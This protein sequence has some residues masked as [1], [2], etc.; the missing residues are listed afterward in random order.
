VVLDLLDRARLAVWLDGG[1]GVDA[2]LGRWSRPHRDLDLV[3]ARGDC[4]A[5]QA[6]LA[7]LGFRHDAAA[8]PGLPARLFLV[9]ADGRPRA[10]G[11]PPPRLP[12]RRQ[13]PP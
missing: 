6:A 7:G 13:R 10:A 2:L 9:H 12:A 5:A 1:W 8:V 11:P 4:A 3:V